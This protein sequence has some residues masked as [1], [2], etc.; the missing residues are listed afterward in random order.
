MTSTTELRIWPH[1]S[2]REGKASLANEKDMRNRI[3]NI[4]A[5][6]ES[7]FASQIHALCRMTSYSDPDATA[8]R[9][10]VAGCLP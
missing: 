9:S 10:H 5:P 8:A 4:M 3:V 7:P 1:V 6:R 2:V